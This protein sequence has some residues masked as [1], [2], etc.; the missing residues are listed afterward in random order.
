L[1][2]KAGWP[3]NEGSDVGPEPFDGKTK[4]VYISVAFPHARQRLDRLSQFETAPQGGDFGV[5]SYKLLRAQVI[6]HARTFA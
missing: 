4:F 1:R 6:D 3:F 2:Q 5:K